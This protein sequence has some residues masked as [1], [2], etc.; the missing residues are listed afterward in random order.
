MN[1]TCFSK[2]MIFLQT[3]F[4]NVLEKSVYAMYYNMLKTMSDEQFDKA[5]REIVRTYIPTTQRPFPMI[6]HFLEA[7]EAAK[8][9]IPECNREYKMIVDKAELPTDEE[10][11][12]FFKEFRQMCEKV[13][14]NS[15]VECTWC[16]GKCYYYTYDKGGY[17]K[18]KCGKCNGTG[19]QKS[20]E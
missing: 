10:R 9:Q 12:A 8:K 4:G 19:K 14:N 5:C 11:A 16:D 20:R 18:V 6:P 7:L 1:D 13:E 2:N 17:Q 15:A 3:Y